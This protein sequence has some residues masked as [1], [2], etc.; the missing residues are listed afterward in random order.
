[1]NA[2]LTPNVRSV[3]TVQGALASR[4]AFAGTAPVRVAEQLNA[5]AEDVSR[6]RARWA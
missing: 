3:L 5:L 1:I 6:A 2:A 4:D